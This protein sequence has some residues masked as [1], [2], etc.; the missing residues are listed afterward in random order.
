MRRLLCAAF[1]AL[2][3]FAAGADVHVV[4]VGGTAIQLRSLAAAPATC[5]PGD[6][7]YDTVTNHMRLC[8]AANTW[9]DE[10][11]ITGDTI[12]G[13]LTFSGFI[14]TD[15]NTFRVTADFTDASST[16]LQNI[17]GLSW[18]LPAST[19]ANY[20]FH[21]ELMYSQ[22]TAAVADAF[23]IQSA[24]LAPTNIAAQGVVVT[25]ATAVAAGNLPTLNT[26]TATNIV[27]FTPSAAAT[28]FG[29]RIS[30]LIENPSGAATAVTI[31]VSQSTAAN[32]IT[33][34]RGSY[35]SVGF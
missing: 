28:V 33:I 12:T 9:A 7:Y 11:D 24:T 26:T 5:A 1:C 18:T 19:A 22:A 16:A 23:G 17:T 29:A 15:G 30:G 27:T 3:A 25:A 4:P 13:S 32:V 31:S 35:C 20:A 34:K 14:R 6:V 8:V 10:V 21:C 2:L